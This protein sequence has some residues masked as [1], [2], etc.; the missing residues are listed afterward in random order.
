MRLRD[1]VAMLGCPV[2]VIEDTSV[3]KAWLAARNDQVACMIFDARHL[4][5]KEAEEMPIRLRSAAVRPAIVWLGGAETPML[6]SLCDPGM[7]EV[8]LTVPATGTEIR[9][10]ILRAIEARRIW[11]VQN[12]IFPKPGSETDKNTG[13][14]P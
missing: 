8:V 9:L 2:M 10:A 13:G 1:E 6:H 3:P 14:N 7:V 5:A 11:L 12:G 4:S